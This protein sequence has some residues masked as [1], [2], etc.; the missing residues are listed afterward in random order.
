M[1]ILVSLF[2]QRLAI[3]L[4]VCVYVLKYVLLSPISSR[5]MFGEAFVRAGGTGTMYRTVF[6]NGGFVST[7][8]S[9]VLRRCHPGCSSVQRARSRVCGSGSQAEGDVAAGLIRTLRWHR[10]VVVGDANWRRLCGLPHAPEGGSGSGGR[11][12]RPLFGRSRKPSRR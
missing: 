3:L 5:M 1:K 10:G 7:V 9:R 6:E 4:P 2:R 11:T 12:G 8:E